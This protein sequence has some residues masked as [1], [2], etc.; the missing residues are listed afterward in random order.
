[1]DLVPAGG[2]DPKDLGGLLHPFAVQADPGDGWIARHEVLRDELVE[3][4]PV[5][6]R[7]VVDRL[8]VAPDELLVL[9]ECHRF[10]SLGHGVAGH[11]RGDARR[12]AGARAAR[13][14]RG[15]CRGRR[16]RAGCAPRPGGAPAGRRGLAA[17]S[18]QSSGGSCSWRSASFSAASSMRAGTAATSAAP[19]PAG[20]TR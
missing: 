5:A 9:L 8:D 13:A 2:C 6:R 20:S 16:A 19:P 7:V 18:I 3:D 10:A 14:N 4:A 12:P 11:Y 17:S 1:P 15:A